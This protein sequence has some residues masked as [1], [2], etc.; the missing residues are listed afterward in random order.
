[1]L[2]LWDWTMYPGERFEGRPHPAGTI[3]LIHVVGGALVLEVNGT[4]HAVA[5]GASLSARTDCAHSYEC[6]GAKRVR[7][8]MVVT[9]KAGP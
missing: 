8:T 9:E 5:T 6:K 1:M 3:E 7:F 4:A 2:E